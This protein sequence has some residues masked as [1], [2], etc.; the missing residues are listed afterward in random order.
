[1][2][3]PIWTPTGWSICMKICKIR[4][5]LADCNATML[6]GKDKG[7]YVFSHD[8][9]K[10]FQKFIITEKTEKF[11]LIFVLEIFKIDFRI[12]GKILSGILVQHMF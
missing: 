8:K 4:F 1:M 12:P 3:D 5:H 10:H 2:I 9:L 7:F 6:G 11:L